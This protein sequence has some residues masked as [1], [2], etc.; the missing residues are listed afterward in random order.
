MRPSIRTFLLINLLL[1][2]TLVTSMAIVG[3]LFIAHKKIQSHLDLQLIDSAKQIHIFIDSQYQSINWQKL[4]H[5]FQLTKDAPSVGKNDYTIFQIWQH[6]HLLLKSSTGNLRDR[7]DI[8]RTGFKEEHRNNQSWRTYTLKDQKNNY[9]IVV[10]QPES[11]RQQLENRLSE[12]SIYL[13]LATYPLL[14]LLVWFIVRNALEPVN[15]IAKQVRHRKAAYLEPVSI[16]NIPAEIKPLTD[17][18]NHLFMRLDEAFER[19]KRFASDAAHEMRTPLAVLSTQAQI[20][21]KATDAKQRNDALKNVLNGVERS[22]HIIH[23]LLT[24]SRM[25]PQASIHQATEFDIVKH[26]TDM[27][28]DLIN[29]AIKKNIELSLDAPDHLHM[30][31]SSTAVAIMI[32]NLIDNAI[33]YTPDNGSVNIQISENTDNKTIRYIVSDTGPGI[34]KELRERV[35]ERFF[36]VIGNKAS[37]SGL[38]LGIV[39]QIVELHHGSINLGTA[40]SGRG[41]KVSITLPSES[42]R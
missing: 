34:A 12:N 18:L 40:D 33:R 42:Q 16:D 32:R 8:H 10:A 20:A 4:N 31:G 35:F 26:T 15:K 29:S 23:Q 38:G 13:L 5:D 25:V 6:D 14:G 36:R 39:K 2:V 3:S 7:F 21:L 19:E 22:S 24:M 1:S 11:Y 30:T 41:L 37:G 27:I 28:G 17:E 9:T